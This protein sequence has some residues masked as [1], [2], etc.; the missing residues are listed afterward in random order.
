[1]NCPAGNHREQSND[2]RNPRVVS[3]LPFT[4]DRIEGE[5]AIL[6]DAKGKT[7]DITIQD[8]PGNSKEGDLL[9]YDGNAWLPVTDA[10][11]ERLN[12]DLQDRLSNLFAR[13]CSIC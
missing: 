13:K 3:R 5:T 9:Q 11:Q 8:L 12:E 6:I 7:F 4:I 2:C 10:V 1:M